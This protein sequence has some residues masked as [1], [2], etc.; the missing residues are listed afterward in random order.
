[1]NAVEYIQRQIATSR[2]VY[3]GAMQ[4]LTDEQFN[5]CPPG[6]TNPISAIVIHA[7]TSEDRFIQQILQGKPRIWET[8]GWAEK[9]GLPVP[10]GGGRGWD[11][12]RG[13]TLAL[14]PVLEYQQAVRA[15]T[16]AYLA[17][18][19]PEDLDRMVS[20]FNSERPA[21]DAFALLVT[22]FA[23]HTGEIAAL[24]GVH[25]VKGLPM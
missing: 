21:A 23:T 1:M 25:G 2:R 13:A 5:W 19:K 6:L 22:H 24:K 11:E 7:L 18:Q 9:I 3:D 14:A 20:M 4:G 17:T 16:D 8:E 12:A 10:P 15:A